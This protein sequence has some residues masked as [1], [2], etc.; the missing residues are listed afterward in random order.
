[1]FWSGP[2]LS[3]EFWNQIVWRWPSCA[4]VSTKMKIFMWPPVPRTKFGM[5]Q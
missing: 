5:T 4:S 1:M 2:R 3:P